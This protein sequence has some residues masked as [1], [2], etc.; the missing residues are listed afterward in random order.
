L[1]INASPIRRSVPADREW[2]TIFSSRPESDAFHIGT[3]HDG[4]FRVAAVG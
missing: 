1:S 3:N 2:P 4:E